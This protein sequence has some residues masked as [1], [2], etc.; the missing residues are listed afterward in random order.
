MTTNK[1]ELVRLV[2]TAAGSVV[3]D[4]TGKLAGRGAYVCGK[5]DCWDAAVR[6]GRLARSLKTTISAEDAG[7]ITAYASSGQGASA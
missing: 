3:V 2:R 6:K 1:R 4:A 5:V 7:A